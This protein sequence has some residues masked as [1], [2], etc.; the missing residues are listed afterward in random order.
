MS[1][2]D[3]D[4]VDLLLVSFWR[5][6]GRLFPRRLPVHRVECCEILHHP[7]LLHPVSSFVSSV[8]CVFTNTCTFNSATKSQFCIEAY[9][10]NRYAIFAVGRVLLNCS[11]TFFDVVVRISRVGEVRTHQFD[12]LVVYLDRCNDDPFVDVLGVTSCST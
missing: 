7:P 9:S 5:S 6:V 1:S 4:A 10:N 11:G 2:L 3:Y 8:E 12:A